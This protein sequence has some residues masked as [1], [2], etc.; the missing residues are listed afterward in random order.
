MLH[1]RVRTARLRRAARLQGNEAI[2]AMLAEKGACS[3]EKYVHQYPH[4]WRS[5]TPIIFRAVEQFFIRIDDIRAER[6]K[7]IDEGELAARL[8]PQPHL[9]HGRSRPDWCISRQ[10][11]W[12]VPL[13]VFYDADGPGHHGRRRRAQGGRRRREHGTNALVRARRRLV[14]DLVGLPR[15]PSARARTPSTSGSTPAAATSPCSTAIPSCTARPMS[16]SRPPTSTAAGSR[17]QP[18]GQRRRARRRALQEPSSPTASSS[19]TSGE[20][21]IS[22]VRRRQAHDRRPLLQQVRWRHGPALGRQRGLPKRSALLSE[23][24]SADRRILP[25]HPQHLRVLLGNLHDDARLQLHSTEADLTLID[26]WI[27]ERLHASGHR[28]AAPPTPPTNSA[29]SSCHQPVLAVE[30]SALYIDIT[31]D[32]LYCDA[33]DS[34]RRRATQAAIRRSPRRS[35][36]CS[37]PSSPSPPTRPG[38]TSAT[39]TACT[40]RPSRNPIPPYRA[41]HRAVPRA[42]SPATAA[43]LSYGWCQTAPAKPQTPR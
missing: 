30:L 29:R 43:P 38:S 7:A 3:A 25:P 13:P 8:G 33:A 28:S 42:P 18:H 39:A 21:K 12:G 6:S 16:I 17:V 1:R 4:C 40:C 2:I 27:L 31:K 5:K 37:P 26:R 35:A 36:A 19:T 10:R 9:R 14:G 23:N 34:P 15:A 41:A 32:R 24:S 22:K 11:T 20:I